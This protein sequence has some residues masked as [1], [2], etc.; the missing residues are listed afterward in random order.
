MYVS[1]WADC[2]KYNLNRLEDGIDKKGQLIKKILGPKVF[3]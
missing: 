1:V 3:N 2:Q